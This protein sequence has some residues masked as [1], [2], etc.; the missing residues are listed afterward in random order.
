MGLVVFSSGRVT[1]I[2]SLY[3]PVMLLP[4]PSCPERVKVN[5]GDIT[6]SIELMKNITGGLRF[7]TV[8]NRQTP[9]FSKSFGSDLHARGTLPAFVF[10]KVYQSGDA[11]DLGFG[12][13]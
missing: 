4:L 10:I 3:E 13:S 1:F 11:F 2:L 7:E 8:G 12:Q 9:V 6:S 5:E